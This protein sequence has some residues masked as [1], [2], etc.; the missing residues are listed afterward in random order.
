MQEKEAI[1]KYAYFRDECTYPDV[2]LM[3]NE[4]I[5]QRQK[6]IQLLESTREL[7]RSRFEVLDQVREG[8]EI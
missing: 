6:S 5:I 2:K 4:L 1:L 8:F 3:L 7:L